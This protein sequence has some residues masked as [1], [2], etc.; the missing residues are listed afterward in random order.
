MV[1]A[2]PHTTYTVNIYVN[3]G[4][5]YT[6][7]VRQRYVTSSGEVFWVFI[8]RNKI[9]KQIFSMYVAPDHPCFGNG[10]DPETM[11]H[12]FPNYDEDTQEIVCITFTQAEIDVIK[13]DIPKG[14]S[15]LQHINDTYVVD[16]ESAPA[17]PTKEVTVGLPEGYDWQM[18]K[19]GDKVEPIKMV[20]PKPANILCRKL[21]AIE[22]VI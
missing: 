8:L 20:I 22:E 7:Y 21:R 2:C 17:W 14:S 15:L 3:V 10:G 11:A 16:D 12:P 6:L 5:G 19:S 18:A 1:Y 9:T 13:T 4:A